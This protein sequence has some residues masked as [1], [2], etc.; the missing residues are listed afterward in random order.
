LEATVE[1]NTAA[2]AATE[3]AAQVVRLRC[4][5]ITEKE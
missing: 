5:P 4:V 1:A 3:I 2:A